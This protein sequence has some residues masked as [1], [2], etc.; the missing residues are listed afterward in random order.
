MKLT[1]KLVEWGYEQAVP[2]LTM[3]A[4]A[5]TWKV[6][7]WGWWRWMN[8]DRK[9]ITGSRGYNLFWRVRWGEFSIIELDDSDSIHLVYDRWGIVDHLRYHPRHG[10]VLVGK[11]HISGEYRA[12]FALIKVEDKG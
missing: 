9:V 11:F 12:P 2:E 4:M 8:F 7:M 5:G 1:K 10:N 3:E 6:R